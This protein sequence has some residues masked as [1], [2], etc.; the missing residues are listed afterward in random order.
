MSILIKVL[1]YAKIS[2]SMHTKNYAKEKNI[3]RKLLA[4]FLAIVMLLTVCIAC[5]SQSKQPAEEVSATAPRLPRLIGAN[6]TPE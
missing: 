5:S 3:M 6:A 4:L 1:T 2:T